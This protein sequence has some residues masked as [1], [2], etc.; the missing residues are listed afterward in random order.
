MYAT[1]YLKFSR[2]IQNLKH[3]ISTNFLSLLISGK[4][5][6]LADTRYLSLFEA[7]YK[8]LKTHEKVQNYVEHCKFRCDSVI[9]MSPWLQKA[10]NFNF[11]S[12]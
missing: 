10:T 12:C 3:I 5:A 9:C 2:H 6:K 7:G 4:L 11:I 1:K 8:E